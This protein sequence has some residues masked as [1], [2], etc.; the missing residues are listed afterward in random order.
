M[1]TV[2]PLGKFIVRKR[3]EFQFHHM[4]QQGDPDSAFRPRSLSVLIGKIEMH[5]VLDLLPGLDK[6]MHTRHF[7]SYWLIVGAYFS[8]ERTGPES[9]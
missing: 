8:R 4:Y 1:W 5:P 2:H 3:V 9:M 6:I 7:H